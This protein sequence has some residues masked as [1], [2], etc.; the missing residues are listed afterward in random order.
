MY[1][2]FS[3]ALLAYTAA[4]MPQDQDQDQDTSVTSLPGT[5]VTVTTLPG[6]STDYT[7]QPEPTSVIPTNLP[8]GLPS[9]SA[10][11]PIGSGTPPWWAHP[12]S[13]RHPIGSGTPTTT[14]PTGSSTPTTSTGP[15]NPDFTGAAAALYAPGTFYAVAGALVGAVLV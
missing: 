15:E 7:P 3:L 1:K 5:S 6:S 13:S 10:T 4:A 8:P 11:H 2:L 14:L 12:S 9:S